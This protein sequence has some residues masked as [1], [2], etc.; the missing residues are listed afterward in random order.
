MK[1]FIQAIDIDMWDIV[2]NGYELP[3]ILI[4]GIVQPKVKSFWTEEKKNK[5]LKTFKVK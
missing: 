5:Y 3:K 4:G 1:D 2:E